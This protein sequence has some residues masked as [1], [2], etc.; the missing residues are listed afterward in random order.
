MCALHIRCLF[1]RAYVINSI[2]TI[3]AVLRLT[4]VQSELNIML[5]SCT[6]IM[7]LSNLSKIQNPQ[8]LRIRLFADLPLQQP[9]LADSVVSF[10]QNFPYYHAFLVILKQMSV[11][12]LHCPLLLPFISVLFFF[13]QILRKQHSPQLIASD[14]ISVIHPR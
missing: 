12:C 7:W 5:H 3:K 11:C 2:K 10:L 6:S 4:H 8:A 14:T 1:Y 13:L 9:F